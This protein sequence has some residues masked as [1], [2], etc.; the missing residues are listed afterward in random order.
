MR[1]TASQLQ[2]VLDRD[3]DILCRDKEMLFKALEDDKAILKEDKAILNKAMSAILQKLDDNA[4]ELVKISG[5]C[6][7]AWVASVPSFN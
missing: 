1:R 4:A 2:M 3:K 6:M 7:F 5:L